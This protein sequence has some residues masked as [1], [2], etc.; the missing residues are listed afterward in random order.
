MKSF[1]NYGLAGYGLVDNLLAS[2]GMIGF[3]NQGGSGGIP[4]GNVWLLEY[5]V[6]PQPAGTNGIWTN[7]GIW[8]SD[9][10]W[11]S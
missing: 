4:S 1:L 2:A 10:I 7:D 3:F 5:S 6:V 11:Y 9:S 8:K